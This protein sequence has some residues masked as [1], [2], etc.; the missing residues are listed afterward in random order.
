MLASP[1]LEVD[2]LPGSELG[3]DVPALPSGSR[4]EQGIYFSGS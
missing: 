4:I 2:A 3:H 1:L